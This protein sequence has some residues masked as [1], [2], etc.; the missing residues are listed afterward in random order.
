MGVSGIGKTT[1]GK[2]LSRR[3]GRKF[4][5][6]D[7]YHW[8]ENRQKMAASIPLSN[9]DRATGLPCYRG[10]AVVVVQAPPVAL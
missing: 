7:D 3:I 4:E 1:S 10:L 9:A 2:L 6:A 5:D 8:Q